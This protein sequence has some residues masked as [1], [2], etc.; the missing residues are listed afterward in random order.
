MDPLTAAQQ[1]ACTNSVLATTPNGVGSLV[2]GR[3]QTPVPT[4]ALTHAL[5]IALTIPL[6]FLALTSTMTFYT[7]PE[8]RQYIPEMFQETELGTYPQ[9]YRYKIKKYHDQRRVIDYYVH[10]NRRYMT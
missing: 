3:N 10:E 5:D 9:V 7:Q 4:L 6:P 1:D 8:T 2:T